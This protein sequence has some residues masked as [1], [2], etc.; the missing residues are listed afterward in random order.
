MPVRVGTVEIAGIIVN[1]TP[2]KTGR[3]LC[4]EVGC[5]N[6]ARPKNPTLKTSGKRAR[7]TGIAGVHHK[8]VQAA[9]DAANALAPFAGHWAKPLFGIGPIGIGA[10][11]YPSDRRNQ[12]LRSE[13]NVRV[14][15][16][17]R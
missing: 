14:G 17:Y 4:L 6:I 11:S 12:R 5:E 10:Y 16:R 3:K 13:R 7:S 9:Q 2:L 1:R 15:R 8:T